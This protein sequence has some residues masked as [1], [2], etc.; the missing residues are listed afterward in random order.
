M[1]LYLAFG[2]LKNTCRPGCSEERIGDGSCNFDCMI[3]ECNYD[4]PLYS[5]NKTLVFN[6]SDCRWLCDCSDEKLGDGK[7]DPQ[8]SDHSCGYDFGDCGHCYPGCYLENLESDV[9]IYECLLGWCIYY[10]KNPCKTTCAPDVRLLMIYT[11]MYAK[12]SA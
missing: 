1:R 2:E 5:D 7:C 8:C 9:C 3:P 10:D 6:Q 11:Q 4:S 12:K